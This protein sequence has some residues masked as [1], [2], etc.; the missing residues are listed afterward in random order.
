MVKK[1]AP[2]ISNI[3]FVF[4]SSFGV[5]WLLDSIISYSGFTIPSILYTK[6]LLGLAFTFFA[7]FKMYQFNNDVVT[8]NKMI[9]SLMPSAQLIPAALEAMMVANGL[10]K[11]DNVPN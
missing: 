1:L 8:T 6:E 4:V 5:A 10:L 11:E 2:K 3:H 9:L 7:Y